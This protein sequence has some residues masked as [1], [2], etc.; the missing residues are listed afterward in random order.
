[1]STHSKPTSWLTKDKKTYFFPLICC[2]CSSWFPSVGD[3]KFHFG[4]CKTLHRNLQCGHCACI[5]TDWHTFIMHVN[6][7]GM[8]LAQPYSDVFSWKNMAHWHNPQANQNSDI[9]NVAMQHANLT[10]LPTQ[11]LMI[12]D[13]IVSTSQD[14]KLPILSVPQSSVTTATVVPDT[15]DTP[16]N[17]CHASIFTQ[18]TPIHH[19]SS[20]SDLE[21]SI[22]I[23]LWQTHATNLQSLQEHVN[24]L[25]QL[26]LLLAQLLL[27][28]M[29]PDRFLTTHEQFVLQTSVAQFL[30]PSSLLHCSTVCEL[31][32]AMLAWLYEQF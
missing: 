17:V 22:P 7:K 24:A 8:S 19:L 21:I 31:L 30:W 6:V 4:N 20:D 11:T 9:L 32:N 18:T 5:F 27:Y 23:S 2:S 26:N 16:S 25:L 14:T 10:H 12:S 28:R 13:P 1:M 29:L 15:S 3:M